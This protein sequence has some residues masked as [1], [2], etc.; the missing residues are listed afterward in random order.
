MWLL[1]SGQTD[2]PPACAC[3]QN[4]TP[5]KMNRFKFWM[6][7][8]DLYVYP[9]IAK[10]SFAELDEWYQYL[11]YKHPWWP[12]SFE[13][14]PDGKKR[15]AEPP[16]G[17]GEVCAACG[18][19]RSIQCF[20]KAL[21]DYFLHVCHAFHGK[22]FTV[23][24]AA[25]HHRSASYAEE[26]YAR[27]AA[28][29]ARWAA[30]KLAYDVVARNNGVDQVL[31]ACALALVGR[32]MLHICTACWDALA[33]LDDIAACCPQGDLKDQVQESFK[34][35]VRGA[36]EN[37]KDLDVAELVQKQIERY[38][39]VKSAGGCCGAYGGCAVCT[40]QTAGRY[41]CAHVLVLVHIVFPLDTCLH[42]RACTL[43][44]VVH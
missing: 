2:S 26:E 8:E 43:P 16:P 22:P 1:T 34:K 12:M 25:T 36:Q 15:I 33:L 37:I 23:C 6:L 40:L 20:G 17:A 5:D 27:L 31:H 3:I 32:S 7:G 39:K 41:S 44:L 28:L 42:S 24:K 29:S 9:T 14:G 11:L 35:L 21:F 4:K 13:V 19:T 30:E 38:S 10:E 18:C